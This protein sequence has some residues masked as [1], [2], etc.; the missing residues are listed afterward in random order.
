M[1]ITHLFCWPS[2]ASL[3]GALAIE[4]NRPRFAKTS[5]EPPPPSTPADPFAFIEKKFK[6]YYLEGG[7][8]E[9][10]CGAC[11]GMTS[12]LQLMPQAM[13]LAIIEVLKQKT[14]S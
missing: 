2:L 11:E 3:P 7:V 4:I 10:S 6:H 13:A 1:R 5:I 8:D 12:P 9:A 14:P